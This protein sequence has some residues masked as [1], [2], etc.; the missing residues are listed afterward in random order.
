MKIL[1]CIKQVPDISSKFKVDAGGE[2]YDTTDLAWRMNEYDE[3]AVEQAI[4]LKEQVQNADIT[5]LSIGPPRVHESIKKALAMGCDWAVHIVDQE[6]DR[7]EPLEIA[8]IIAEYARDKEFELIFTGTQSQDQGRA[9][10][11]VLIG[12][13]LSMA[14]VTT[15]IDFSYSNHR[16]VVK[17]ELEEGLRAK[18]ALNTPALVTCQLGLNTPRYPTI[19]NI[20]KAMKKERLTILVQDLIQV[21]ARQEATRLFLPEKQNGATVLEGEPGDL[22]EQLLEILKTRTTVLV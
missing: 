4:Q 3:I 11:G 20:L 2:W 16:I 18:V 13:M 14:S 7:R 8:A 21:A 17:R 19:P 6:A 10:V 5:V 12:E 9:Q 15:V 22:A 1:V